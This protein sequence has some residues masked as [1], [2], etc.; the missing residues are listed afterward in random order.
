[1][2][3]IAKWKSNTWYDSMVIECLTPRQL[4]IAEDMAV[5]NI[6]ILMGS[7]DQHYHLDGQWTCS[8]L[9]AGE[10][11]RQPV[12]CKVGHIVPVHPPF[13]TFV[14]GLLKKWS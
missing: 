14:E 3:C 11:S 13:F 4:I 1:M 5:W 8:D 9:S 7:F 6:I 12:L 10:T 2:I